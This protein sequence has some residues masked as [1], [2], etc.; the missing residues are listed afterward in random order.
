[1]SDRSILKLYLDYYQVHLLSTYMYIPDTVIDLIKIWLCESILLYL[2]GS[3]MR[4]KLLAKGNLK[5]M[6]MFF[7]QFFVKIDIGQ[8]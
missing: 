7:L 8:L 6:T 1:M 4:V 2:S 3:K 5:K